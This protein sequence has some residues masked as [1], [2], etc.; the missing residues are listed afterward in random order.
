[1]ED[2]RAKEEEIL[3]LRKE[4]ERKEIEIKRLKVEQ[5]QTIQKLCVKNKEIE[6]TVQTSDIATDGNNRVLSSFKFSTNQTKVDETSPV[7]KVEQDVIVNQEK[8][9]MEEEKIKPD[10][11]PPLKSRLDLMRMASAFHNLG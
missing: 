1:M 3:I 8:T 9:L 6:N 11:K 2:N 5:T 4:L 10:M 7:E